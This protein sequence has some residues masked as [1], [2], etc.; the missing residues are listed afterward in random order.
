MAKINEEERKRIVMALEILNREAPKLA[1]YPIIQPKSITFGDY[2]WYAEVGNQQTFSMRGINIWNP[3]MAFTGQDRHNL[4]SLFLK[5][6]TYRL[7]NGEWQ[8]DTR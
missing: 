8:R 6:K 7:F 1:L 4:Y 5:T 2:G 3:H